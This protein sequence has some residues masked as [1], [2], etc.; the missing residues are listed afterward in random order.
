MCIDAL[1]SF[2][3]CFRN[4]TSM[5]HL[6]TVFLTV[7][8]SNITCTVYKDFCMQHLCTYLKFYIIFK[9]LLFHIHTLFAMICSVPPVKHCHIPNPFHVS[10]SCSSPFTMSQLY[11]LG[12]F[13]RELWNQLVASSS[14]SCVFVCLHEWNCN[15]TKQFC[16]KND[17]GI[18]KNF[19]ILHISQTQLYFTSSTVGIQL[20][21][22]ALYVGHLQV[23]IQLTQQLYKMC[24]VFF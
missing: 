21:V 8:F 11:F 3:M 22:S 5:A 20:H 1:Y 15:S 2:I 6:K 4:P 17:N 23:E 14:S 12:T 9:E 10:L 7:I 19:C 13:K 24:G 16:M 18:T